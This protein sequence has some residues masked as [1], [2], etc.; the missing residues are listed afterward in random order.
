V[1]KSS[2][3]DHRPARAAA[4]VYHGLELFKLI[5]ILKL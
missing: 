4:E 1:L 3:L 2:H 5:I